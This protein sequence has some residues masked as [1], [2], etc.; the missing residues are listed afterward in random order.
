MEASDLQRYKSL[1]LGKRSELMAEFET[2]I[3]APPARLS[4]GDFSDQARA[5][6]D[7]FVQV[8]MRQSDVETLREIEAALVRINR[9]TF[10]TCQ[11]CKKPLSKARLEAV[12]WTRF[13][14]EC[15]EE[16]T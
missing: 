2:R 15:G 12:P 4:E 7:A 11:V 16:S 9:A 5:D 8:G 10:G 14:R 3:V 1:L 6:E 13:C